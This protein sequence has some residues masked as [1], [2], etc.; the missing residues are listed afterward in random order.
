[1]MPLVFREIAQGKTI[2]NLLLGRS[3]AGFS[4]LLTETLQKE[5]R[6]GWENFDLDLPRLDFLE[7]GRL[8]PVPGTN[9]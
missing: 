8:F 2:T 3:V 5:Q 1:M 7:L 4:D 6:A 9:S